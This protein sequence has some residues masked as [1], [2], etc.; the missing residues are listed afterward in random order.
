M[1]GDVQIT[2]RA[3]CQLI[4]QPFVEYTAKLWISGLQACDALRRDAFGTRVSL[5]SGEQTWYGQLVAGGSYQASNERKLTFGLGNL[6]RI[7]RLTV[8]WPSGLTQEFADL[9]VSRRYVLVEGSEI[10]PESFR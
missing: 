5:S 2:S 1:G 9:P 8:E 4:E 6:E 3:Y 7:D 10:L